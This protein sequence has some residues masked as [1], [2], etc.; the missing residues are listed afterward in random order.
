M[1]KSTESRR[2]LADNLKYFMNLHGKT[3]TEVCNDLKIR[4]SVLSSW[5]SATNYPRIDKIEQ[6]AQYFNLN[7][8]DLIESPKEERCNLMSSKEIFAKNLKRLMDE[9]G[10]NQKE[11]AELIGISPTAINDWLLCKKYPRMDKIEM[12]AYHFGISKSDLIDLPKENKT[13]DLLQESAKRKRKINQQRKIWNDNF[14]NTLFT[15]EQFKEIINFTKYILSK[16]D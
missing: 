1:T 13:E 14:G 6:L 12:L 7:K 8:S 10:K 16:T 5:L 3:R 11:M 9:Y 4:Y 2:V 15:E